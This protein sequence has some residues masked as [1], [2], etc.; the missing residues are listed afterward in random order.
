MENKYEGIPVFDSI[1]KLDENCLP[2]EIELDAEK[3]EISFI[4]CSSDLA[5]ELKNEFLNSREIVYDNI[6]EETIS[7]LEKQI[8]PIVKSIQMLKDMQR[9]ISKKF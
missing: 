2:P 8:Q 4:E 1:K 5:C 6:L 3:D 9:E 7:R